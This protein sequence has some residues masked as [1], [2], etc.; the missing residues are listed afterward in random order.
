MEVAGLPCEPYEELYEKTKRIVCRVDSPGTNVMRRGPVVVR[1]EDFRGESKQTYEFVDPSIESISPKFGPRSGGTLLKIQ[2]NYMNAGSR[3]QAF[4]DTLP[5]E[6][7]STSP[8]EALC[9]TS[10]SDRQRSGKVKMKFDK[11][12]RSYDKELFEYVEDPT[13]E[14]AESGVASQ[15]SLHNNLHFLI[16][17]L[18]RSFADVSYHAYLDETHTL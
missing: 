5:C 10:A 14:S 2:G 8:N 9:I 6:I 11:G 15:V 17:Y 16:P 18:K 7:I 3:I 12:D 1:V 13:I 4:I